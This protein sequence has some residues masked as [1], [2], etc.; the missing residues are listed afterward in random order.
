MVVN[1][2]L[3]N[4]LPTPRFPTRLLRHCIQNDMVRE[5]CAQK[6][7]GHQHIHAVDDLRPAITGEIGKLLAV[8]GNEVIRSVRLG[9]ARRLPFLPE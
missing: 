2:V 5:R 3:G 7:S 1:L 6:L 8:P 9:Q 4:P